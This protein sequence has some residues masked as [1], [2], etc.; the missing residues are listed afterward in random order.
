[1]IISSFSVILLGKEKYAKT[2]KIEYSII[3]VVVDLSTTFP[4]LQL[5][6]LSRELQIGIVEY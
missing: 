5:V 2:V 1:M 4:T 6:G 3:I